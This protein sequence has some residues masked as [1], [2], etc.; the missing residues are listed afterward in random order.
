MHEI[1]HRDKPR[2]KPTGIKIPVDCSVQSAH[3]YHLATKN[4]TDLGVGGADMV[5]HY[6]TVQ[7][8]AAPILRPTK[9][10]TIEQGCHYSS[11]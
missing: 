8:H 10:R 2:D 3:K 6:W 9:N 5:G 1:N 11:I 7:D 4:L